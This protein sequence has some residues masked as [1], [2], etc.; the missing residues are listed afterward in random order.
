M[1]RREQMP[2]KAGQHQLVPKALVVSLRSINF[3][4]GFRNI[5]AAAC[6]FRVSEAA[7]SH[8]ENLLRDREGFSG[9]E[10]APREALLEPVS[11]LLSLSKFRDKS[12][13]PSLWRRGISFRDLPR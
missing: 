1:I 11:V 13:S 7:K 3:T 2:A 5:S 8:I 9:I 4:F 6:R 12:A 10:I